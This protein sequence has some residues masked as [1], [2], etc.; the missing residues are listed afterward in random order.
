MRF[1]LTFLLCFLSFAKPCEGYLL[2][3]YT[4]GQGLG[5]NKG[6]ASLELFEP[7]RI[8]A[9][10]RPFYDLQVNWFEKDQYAVNFGLGF[11]GRLDPRLGAFGI[12]AFYDY[13]N[14]H[15]SSFNQLGLGFE[16]FGCCWELYVNGYLPVGKKERE[17][18][19][20]L[21]DHYEGGFKIRT[22]EFR[23]ALRGLDAEIGYHVP[24]CCPFNLYAGI[25]GYYY[26]GNKCGKRQEGAKIRLFS[27]LTNCLNLEVNLLHD[28]HSKRRASATL[29]YV[30]P[31]G[32]CQRCSKCC[33]RPVNRNYI[34][35][36][37][38]RCDWDW[39]FHDL[40]SSGSHS[41][42]CGH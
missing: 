14:K 23:D 27:W 33:M 16:Y 30:A 24:L 6:Y 15:D 10:V 4:A 12:N 11:R 3:G 32:S 28:S 35:N 5:Y 36:T 21:F 41:C 9:K 13:Y 37:N 26:G 29:T 20:C 40:I 31:I 22:S 34:I 19:T 18:K 1:F 2:V 7:L 42:G 17:V 39:N 38:T 8:D 25:G